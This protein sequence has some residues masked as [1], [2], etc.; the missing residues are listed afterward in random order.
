MNKINDAKKILDK[1]KEYYDKLHSQN[2][3][4]NELSKN[5]N[6][7]FSAR[8]FNKGTYNEYDYFAKE[9]IVKFLIKKGHTIINKEEDYKHDLVTCK[10]GINHYFELEV[11]IGYPFTFKNDYKFNTVSFLS[12]K[13]RLHNIFPFHYLIICKETNCVLSCESNDIFKDEF[14]EKLTVNTTNRKGN[15]EMYRVPIE[16]CIFFNIT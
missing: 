6:N 4:D 10:N 15:D 11:K 8:E 7:I 12:R 1:A 2:S 14:L 9:K 5:E 13:K 3:K 16:K